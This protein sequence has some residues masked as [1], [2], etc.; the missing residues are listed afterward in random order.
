MFHV[1]LVSE[2]Y[3]CKDFEEKNNNVRFFQD[4]YIYYNYIYLL[5]KIPIIK[6]KYFSKEIVSWNSH[7]P[8]PVASEVWSGEGGYSKLS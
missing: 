7:F 1:P 8:S 3:G 4:I 6:G 2:M 5:N